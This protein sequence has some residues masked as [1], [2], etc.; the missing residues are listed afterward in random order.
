MTLR[1]AKAPD[2]KGRGLRR[3]HVGN[4]RIVTEALLLLQLLSVEF[5]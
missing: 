3:F 5:G 2:C 4:E 1:K